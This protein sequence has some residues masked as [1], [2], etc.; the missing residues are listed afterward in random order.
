MRKS[1]KLVKNDFSMANAAKH[2]TERK[3][4]PDYEYQIYVDGNIVWRG[5]N[6]EGKYEEIVKKNP[7]KKVS[8]GWNCLHHM[9]R[10]PF[11]FLPKT[12]TF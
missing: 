10:I 2:L 7:Q 5:L 9:L 4:V 8:I 3:D 11:L 1:Y 6:L 12:I